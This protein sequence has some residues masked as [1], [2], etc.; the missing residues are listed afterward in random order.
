MAHDHFPPAHRPSGSAGYDALQG[1]D[2]SLDI[3]TEDVAARDVDAEDVDAEDVELL[4]E[5]D[6][7][8]E[9]GSEGAL[10]RSLLS[11]AFTDVA[12]SEVRESV[13]SAVD[14]VLRELAAVPAF[15]ADAAPVTT[16]SG[17]FE[18]RRPAEAAS[19]MASSLEV[20][21]GDVAAVDDTAFDDAVPHAAGDDCTSVG[22]VAASESAGPVGRVDEA[23]IEQARSGGPSPEAAALEVAVG[24]AGTEPAS[25]EPASV[26]PASVEPASVEAA[27]VP[28][29]GP[30]RSFEAARPGSSARPS[31]VEPSC[32][33]AV[34]SS[35][36]P[37]SVNSSSINSSSGHCCGGPMVGGRCRSTPPAIDAESPIIEASGAVPALVGGV[38]GGSIAS[39]PGQLRVGLAGPAAAN[40]APR[41]LGSGAASRVARF[42]AGVFA[43]ARDVAVA[44]HLDVALAGAE[45]STSARLRDGLVASAFNL[46]QLAA[47]IVVG[48]VIGKA[49]HL[50]MAGDDALA[51]NPTAEAEG[52]LRAE[53]S[54]TPDVARTSDPVEASHPQGKS[55]PRS[56]RSTRR[57]RAPSAGRAS[58]RA[59]APVRAEPG[60]NARSAASC[61]VSVTRTPA[62]ASPLAS[63]AAA[64]GCPPVATSVAVSSALVPP[65]LVAPL[66]LELSQRVRPTADNVQPPLA[67]ASDDWLG[68]Q[69]A[70][71]G[72]AERSLLEDDPESAVRSLD[73]YKAR[74]PDG[75]LDPQM[76]SIRQRVEERFTAFIF[77]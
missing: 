47:A 29:G 65:P 74:F 6:P 45:R 67:P 71:L 40:A 16:L 36:K 42:E 35:V 56:A 61:G 21:R 48:I 8:I 43:P 68:E 39:D 1:W 57:P 19:C 27:F 37:G 20:P 24:A 60:H 12:P 52:G 33:A 5:V 15:P 72:R 66:A 73:E 2:T 17:V 49:A 11:A 9:W 23:C 46:A 31:L 18:K 32:G 14:T 77:P 69:L 4:E 38:G 25:V 53:P 34:A 41:T 28:L 22:A 44:S 75:L 30:A 58:L 63:A 76:A 26:E 59:N 51:W 7:G 62:A 54:R 50:I 55:E 64:S 70:I 3:S 10:A 13:L